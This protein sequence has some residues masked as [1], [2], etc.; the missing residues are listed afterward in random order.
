MLLGILGWLVVGAVVGFIASKVI[1]LRGDDPRLGIAASIGGAVV[2]AA[3]A[4]IVSGAGVMP[5]SPRSLAF[6]AGGAVVS[7]IVW[8]LVRSRYVSHASYTRRSS[9]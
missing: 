6:A 2:V 8:H 5:W 3:I 1:N 4:A 9:Y 7:V